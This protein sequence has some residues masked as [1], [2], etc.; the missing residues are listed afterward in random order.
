MILDLSPYNFY[1][2]VAP[3][4][5]RSEASEIWKSSAEGRSAEGM[6]V[7]KL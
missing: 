5:P 2:A 3:L 1:K 6:T 4:R 7:E